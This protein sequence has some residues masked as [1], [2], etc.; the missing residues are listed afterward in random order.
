M[1]VRGNQRDLALPVLSQSPVQQ[2]Q[3][4]ARLKEPDKEYCC[5]GCCHLPN[6]WEKHGLHGGC[7]FRS[8]H[9]RDEVRALVLTITGRINRNMQKV[10]VKDL[11]DKS[12]CNCN[13]CFP[14]NT[15]VVRPDGKCLFR[16]CRTEEQKDI[17]KTL[18]CDGANMP[19]S[20]SEFYCQ[21]DFCDQLSARYKDINPMGHC[22]F[23]HLRD[24]DEAKTQLLRL[25][26]TDYRFGLIRQDMEYHTPGTHHSS[27]SSSEDND[28]DDDDDKP[29][30]V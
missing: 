22:L 13:D 5:W 27:D 26:G 11:V 18:L 19:L 28:D 20:Q 7:I 29:V 25:L 23:E 30:D 4:K 3:K 24:D 21:C 15:E 6:D 12:V 8:C 14:F 9:T 17:L 2:E 1:D 10:V 16:L